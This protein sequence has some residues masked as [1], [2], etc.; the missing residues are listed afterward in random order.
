MPLPPLNASSNPKGEQGAAGGGPEASC[1]RYCLQQNWKIHTTKYLYFRRFVRCSC[2]HCCN[3]W[4]KEEFVV[5]VSFILLV[6]VH[7]VMY[8]PMLGMIIHSVNF[9]SH[10]SDIE[11]KIQKNLK[12]TFFEKGTNNQC[13]T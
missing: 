10:I 8:L 13:L 9:V 5:V 12:V 11:R 3:S 4:C 2:R 1:K 7:I 6:C